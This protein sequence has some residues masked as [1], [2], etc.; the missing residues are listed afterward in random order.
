MK[1]LSLLGIAVLALTTGCVTGSDVDQ[2]NRQITDL[3]DQIAD[4]KRQVSSKDEVQQLNSR[5]AQQTQT[6]LKSNADVAT[7]V[8][9]IDDRLQNTQGAVEQTNYRLDRLAQQV[10]QQQRDIND[11]KA[12][13]PARSGTGGALPDGEV[14]VQA[15]QSEDPL[16]VYQTAY[17]DYQRGNFDLA[18]AGFRDF[19]DANPNS[20][21]A[22]NAA[23]WIGESLYSQKK[24]RDAIQQFDA[25]INGYPE[26][27][28]VPAAL[29]KKGYS[30]VELG[31]R[32]QGIVQLQYVLHEHPRAPEAAL[33]REKLKTLGIDGN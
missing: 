21:L 31:Q 27:D 33:A 17:R 16:E 2:L 30:Y 14:R 3:Q 15:P 5:V 18:L 22:D 23:Y 20:D 32:S 26:S 10:T 24:F 29:L 1:A 7:K 25:V 9:E 6:L 4:L 13:A 11:L 19:I 12:G 8:T 28:R